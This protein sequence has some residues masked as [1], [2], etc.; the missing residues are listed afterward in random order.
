[1]V[2][3][4]YQGPR[5]VVRDVAGRSDTLR[6][7]GWN[8]SSPPPL[9]FGWNAVKEG[10]GEGVSL[11]QEPLCLQARNMVRSTSKTRFLLERLF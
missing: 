11:G 6:A 10:V 2:G 3:M 4:Y 7:V 8:H 5:R 1:M 9:R